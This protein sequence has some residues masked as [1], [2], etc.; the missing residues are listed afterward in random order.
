MGF[1]NFPFGF[2]VLC[3]AGKA[4]PLLESR[5][6][7]R[8]PAVV[9]PHGCVC[10]ACCPH[11]SCRPLPSPAQLPRLCLHRLLPSGPSFRGVCGPAH[12]GCSPSQFL[13]A[14]FL[15]LPLAG[16]PPGALPLHPSPAGGL[17]GPRVSPAG[18]HASG[19][20]CGSHSLLGLFRPRPAPQA[21]RI[22]DSRAHTCPPQTKHL[23]LFRGDLPSRSSKA[24]QQEWPRPCSPPR[25]VADSGLQ[26]CS[27]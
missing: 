22:P 13:G 9:P 6:W 4:H 1:V 11:A 3:Q 23:T 24:K 19:S 14:S 16:P 10:G 8:P 17:P 21:N 15:R 25:P 12:L 26:A 2:W 27:Q 7:S 5:G 20:L 18:S